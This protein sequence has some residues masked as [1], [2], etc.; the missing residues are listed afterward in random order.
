[1][2]RFVEKYSYD[3]F[4][5]KISELSGHYLP[6]ERSETYKKFHQICSAAG[7]FFMFSSLTLGVI[8]YPE[9]LRRDF[10]D[11]A[12]AL[13]INGTA[14]ISGFNVVVMLINR[15]RINGLVKRLST[16]SFHLR[17]QSEKNLKAELEKKF[18]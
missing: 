5:L 7:Y 9:L 11:F 13:S 10:F 1:M 4:V 6:E 12:Y 16:K 17:S 14:I 3:G 8:A 2:L 15:E 18:L